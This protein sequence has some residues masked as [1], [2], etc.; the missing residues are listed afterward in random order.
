MTKT[1]RATLVLVLIFATTPAPSAQDVAKARTLLEQALTAL[2]PAPLP[3]ATA[4][5]F[6][7]ALAAAAPGAVLELDPTLVYL[8]ALTLRQAVTLHSAVPPGRV[9]RDTPLPS[10][11]GGLTITGADVTLVGL[12]VRHPNPLTD[13]LVVIGARA[14]LDQVRV[15]GDAVKGA[16]RCISANS[17]GALHLVRAYVDDCFASSPGA[18]SQ[19]IAAWDMGPGL[20]V[21]D[22][23]LSGGSETVLLGGADAPENRTPDGVVFDGNTITKHAEWQSLPIGVK[24]LVE[25]KNAK[26]VIFRNNTGSYA[27]VNGQTGY[28]VVLSVRNQDGRAPWATIQHVLF[29][30]NTWS[31]GGG[32][33]NILGRDDIKETG[34]GRDVPV[35]TVRRSV[36]MQDVVIRDTFSIDPLKYGC[37]GVAAGCNMK[38]ILI[39]GGPI[40]TT[41]DGVT[42]STR[43][44]LGSAVYWGSGPTATN[45][46]LTN[47]T[48]PTS[49]FGM[50]SV[51][52]GSK[53]YTATNLAW[54]TYVSGGTIANITVTP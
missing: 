41:L 31:D 16:K 1:L 33:I 2:Q 11:R 40:D 7:T 27:W 42:V 25:I 10:F 54:T 39:G 49:A 45:F 6:D 29:E 52:G 3:I 9:T 18:D 36:P 23:Y 53:T 50:F 4:A 35:G 37:R 47:T 34:A 12:E 48:L 20:L 13:I 21:E 28:L 5:A 19:A 15:V 38:A 8:P 26:H 43:S 32:A 22:S 30:K 44:P 51:V 46:T 24:N 17:D 14:T